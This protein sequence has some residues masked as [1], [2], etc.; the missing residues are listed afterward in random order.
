M[1]VFFANISAPKWLLLGL[2]SILTTILSL[3]LALVGLLFFILI[4]LYTG[5]KKYI[6]I[7]NIKVEFSKKFFLTLKSGGL[8]DS[9]NK[10]GEYLFTILMVVVFES[11][12]FNTTSIELQGRQFTLSEL[13][14]IIACSI[15]MWSLFENREVYTG[16]NP[17]KRLLKAIISIRKIIKYK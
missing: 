8:R 14:V 5:I 3:K 9:Y 1:N 2:T 15:E 7:N 10:V 6:F 4:D 12:V 11:L 13:S 16:R 17:L